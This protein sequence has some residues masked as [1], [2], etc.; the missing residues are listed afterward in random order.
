[1]HRGQV[2]AEAHDALLVADPQ[3]TDSERVSQALYSIAQSLLVIADIM[4]EETKVGGAFTKR[5]E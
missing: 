1:M 3:D 4:N 5:T 2:L